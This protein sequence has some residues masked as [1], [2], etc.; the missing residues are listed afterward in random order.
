MVDLAT[1]TYARQNMCW[2]THPYLNPSLC[3]LAEMNCL[4]VSGFQDLWEQLTYDVNTVTWPHT[5]DYT[6]PCGVPSGGCS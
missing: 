3:D 5:H 2:A 4:I 1:M 6:L